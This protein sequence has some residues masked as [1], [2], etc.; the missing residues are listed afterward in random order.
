MNGDG[1]T[2]ELTVDI[3]GKHPTLRF[4]LIQVDGKNLVLASCLSGTPAAKLPKWRITIRHGRLKSINDQ[5]VN[6]QAEAKATDAIVIA[7]VAS[8]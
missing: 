5:S 6:T 2:T 4:D 3:K 7:S 1:P 8:A